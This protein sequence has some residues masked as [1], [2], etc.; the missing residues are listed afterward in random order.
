GSGKRAGEDLLGPE[1]GGQGPVEW[2]ERALARDPGRSDDEP[3]EQR[4]ARDEIGHHEPLVDEVWLEPVPRHHV[5]GRG[6]R[7]L[8]R[9]RRRGEICDD[10]IEIAADDL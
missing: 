3:N 6:R 4:E 8:A 7:S 5:D 1:R 10:L 2:A 9:G